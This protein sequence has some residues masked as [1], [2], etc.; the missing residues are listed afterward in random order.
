MKDSPIAWTENTFNPW[1]GCQKV[2]PGCANCYAEAMSRRNPAVLGRWGDQGT[3]VIATDAWLHPPK[4]NREA[5]AAGQRKKVFCA[6]LADV[7]EDRPE[8]IA[9]RRRLFDLIGQT[10]N[11]DWQLLT[12]RPENFAALLP[13]WTTNLPANVWLGVTAEDQPRAEERLPLLASAPAVVRF[14]SCEPLLAPVDLTCWLAT[15][16][17]N[18]VIVGGESGNRRRPMELAWLEAIVGQCRAF[19]IPVFVK[20]DGALRDGKQ[21]RIPDALWNLKEFPIAVRAAASHADGAGGTG[22]D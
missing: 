15:G 10:P 18:W 1:R 11:L 20:Q 12:K 7:F 14:V 9:P 8:L 17:L 5:K 3:R 19:S 6:S 2:S 16:G 4:W 13:W 22:S 21:G